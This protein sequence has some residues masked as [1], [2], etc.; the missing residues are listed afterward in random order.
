MSVEQ[1]KIIA[2]MLGW[3]NFWWDTGMTPKG[4]GAKGI[5]VGTDPQGSERRIPAYSTNREAAMDGIEALQG[6]LKDN[7]EIYIKLSRNKN[8]GKDVEIAIYF[9]G[10]TPDVEDEFYGADIWV[11][12]HSALAAAFADAMTEKYEGTELNVILNISTGVTKYRPRP[13]LDAAL[14]K[15]KRSN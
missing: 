7:A 5:L 13:A 8:K 2:G 11:F 3:T 15:A 9:S 10:G 14:R 4:S 6:K 1:D 12:G